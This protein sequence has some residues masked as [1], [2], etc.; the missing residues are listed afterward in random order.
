MDLVNPDSPDLLAIYPGLF[1]NPK[2][3]AILE[4]FIIELF[5]LR[6]G[7]NKVF[8]SNIETKFKSNIDLKF[9]KLNF[10]IFFVKVIPE[11]FTITSIFLNFF[12]YNFI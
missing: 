11:Q 6:R 8:S 5:F 12:F 7:I 9:L 1:S 2:Y 3:E 4:M 10:G